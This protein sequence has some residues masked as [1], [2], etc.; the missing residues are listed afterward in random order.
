MSWRIASRS[1]PRLTSKRVDSAVSVNGA[2]GAMSPARIAARRR[3][4]IWARSVALGTGPRPRSGGERSERATSPLPPDCRLLT[5]CHGL[6]HPGKGVCQPIGSVGLVAQELARHGDLHPVALLVG[7]TLHGHVEV[8]GRHDAVA[9]L[10]LD[11]LLPGRA[12]DL[13]QFVETVDQRIGRRHLGQR[14]AIGH[15]LQQQGL[16]LAEAEQRGGLG[17]LPLGHLH[18]AHA[19]GGDDDLGGAAD[20]LGDLLPAQLLQPL[21]REGLLRYFCPFH[22]SSLLVFLFQY[23]YLSGTT[24]AGGLTAAKPGFTSFSR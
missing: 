22:L 13:H 2:P 23:V 1:G 5:I 21:G 10:L 24:S 9:E 8:D 4:A 16:F 11:Q 18:L 15:L 12:V 20:L 17:R 7:L 19:G 14:A 6:T 3:S